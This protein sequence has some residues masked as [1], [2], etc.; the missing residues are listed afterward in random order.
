RVLRPGGLL[1]FSSFAPG[2]LQELRSAWAE[3]D[4]R[5]H[6][7]EFA[8]LPQVAEALLRSGFIEPVIDVE[9]LGRHY[10]DLKALKHE[11]KQ[12]EARPAPGIRPSGLGGRKRV[13]ALRR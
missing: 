9:R 4:A 2:T 6:V 12:M 13:Q 11:L 3:V 10:P 5:V 7:N 1:L 8:D